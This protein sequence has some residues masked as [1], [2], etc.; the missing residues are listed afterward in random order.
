MKKTL[1]SL[2]IA[3]VLAPTAFAAPKNKKKKPKNADTDAAASDE[4]AA[5]PSNGGTW[6]VRSRK[7]VW[8]AAG[9]GNVLG[10]I[11]GGNVEGAYEMGPA[12]QVG[13]GVALGSQDIP[14]D[15]ANDQVV[16][17]DEA[18]IGGTLFFAKG[19]YF[20]GNSFNVAGVLSYRV[21]TASAKINTVDGTSGLDMEVKSTSIT[22]GVTIGN[23]WAFNNGLTLGADWIGY[24]IPLTSGAK[25]TTTTRGVL[26]GSSDEFAKD[27]QDAGE[28]LGKTAH[29]QLLVAT[30][31]FLF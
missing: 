27:T 16:K 6:E 31:G 19:R 12:L 28:T 14:L 1:L 18:K 5:P 26:T 9:G 29:A 17:V 10:G 8:V 24:H 15:D 23:H 11:T 22:A 2:L 3:G 20:F 13:G 25:T 30:I 21:I 7:K 4:P